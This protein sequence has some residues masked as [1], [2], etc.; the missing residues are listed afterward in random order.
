MP[1]DVLEIAG[2]SARPG[3]VV[4][5]RLWV[6]SYPDGSEVRVPFVLARGLGARAGAGGRRTLLVIAGLHGPEVPG[7]EVV[8]RILTDGL[9]RTRL[10][11]DLVL[12]PV[13]NPWGFH[14]QEMVTPQDAQNLN[15]VFPGDPEGTTSQR[16]AHRIFDAFVRPASA[17]V[18][19]HANPEPALEFTIYP[20]PPDRGLARRARALAEAYGITS[21]GL[22]VRAAGPGYLFQAAAA[23]GIPGLAVELVAWRRIVPEAV[24]SALVGIRNVLRALDMYPGRC[25]PQTVPRIEARGLRRRVVTVAK[26][27]LLHPFR[28]PGEPVAR[29]ETIAVVRDAFGDVVEEVRS[30]VDGFL[31]AWPWVVSQALVS[32]EIAAFVAYAEPEEEDGG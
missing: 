25:E 12:V 18:D 7:V 16:L 30:P 28:R 14:R 13:A 19:L 15:R 4:R 2:V 23:L 31:L 26:G 29:G 17:L 3:E 11:G 22:P 6:G 27:G 10:A 20:I 21:V 24:E 9:D 1:D 32:G 5:G 8:R